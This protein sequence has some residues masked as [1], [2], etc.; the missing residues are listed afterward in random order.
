[1]NTL[2]KIND[3]MIDDIVL[4]EAI[5]YDDEDEEHIELHPFRVGGVSK[6]DSIWIDGYEC[7]LEGEWLDGCQIEH[8]GDIYGM[9][10]TKETAIANG[11]EIEAEG[12]SS[13]VY[14]LRTADAVI[15]MLLLG[16]NY[17]VNVEHHIEFDGTYAVNS[18]HKCGRFIHEYQHALRDC[19]LKDIANKMKV[20]P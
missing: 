1:M 14:N 9:P 16:D 10:F 15:A 13:A 4:A 19:D 2:L 7:G 11:F 3:L 20:K 18:A 17:V 12:G 6:T 8:I 5:W